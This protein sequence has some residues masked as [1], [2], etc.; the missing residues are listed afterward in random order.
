MALR[1]LVGEGGFVHALSP[2][3]DAGYLA[4]G[5]TWLPTLL[6]ARHAIHF[7]DTS[8]QNILSEIYL[9]ELSTAK[10][11]LI[12]YSPLARLGFWH[13]LRDIHIFEPSD[14]QLKVMRI[15]P[16]GTLND[17]NMHRVPAYQGTPLYA[18][19]MDK[20]GSLCYIDGSSLCT[21][22]LQSHEFQTLMSGLVGLHLE[23][24]SAFAILFIGCR[25]TCR[26][27]STWDVCNFL[28]S[29]HTHKRDNHERR[30]SLIAFA[31]GDKNP[32]FCPL[33]KVV[34]ATWVREA[35]VAILFQDN[36]GVRLA[37]WDIH[38]A[39]TT[40]SPLC[41]DSRIAFRIARLE[42]SGNFALLN[43]DLTHLTVISPWL[44]HKVLT[45][46]NLR[47]KSRIMIKQPRAES[48]RTVRL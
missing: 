21:Y 12:Y 25:Y 23:A 17:S 32:R 30:T 37:F 4:L 40:I 39:K 14:G 36:A 27:V 28:R 22:N 26:T 20:Q 2:H 13:P 43:K 35:E 16:E 8:E 34:D 42:G 33:D 11:H 29:L 46:A 3:P 41:L 1:V 31:P 45:I 15:S 18:V 7:D 10:A 5:V 24:S 19:P 48:I 9:V 6:R 38:R 44:D 47:E